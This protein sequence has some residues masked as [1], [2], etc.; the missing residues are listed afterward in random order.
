MA[1]G[2]DDQRVDLEHLHVLGDEA[3]IELRDEVFG[4]LRERALQAQHFRDQAAVMGHDAGRGIDRERVDFLRGV[5]RD[6][7]DIH[8]AF[9]RDDEGDAARG[10][11]DQHRQIEFA[12]DIRAVLDVEA[13]DLLAGLAGLDG[14]QRVAEHF[15][16]EL[17]HLVDGLGQAHAALFAGRRFLEFALAAAARVDLGFDDPERAAELLCGRLGLVGGED[18]HA[19]RDGK[20]ELFQDG[21]ALVFMDVHVFA[22]SILA[23]GEWRVANGEEKVVQLPTHSHRVLRPKPD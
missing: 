6:R 18:R 21:L 10:A 19:L 8:A 20:P 5:V 3:V 2:G 1:V 11:V 12:L 17:L 23:N 22:L 13:V 14:D 16:R 4:F 7:L 9:G 15:A